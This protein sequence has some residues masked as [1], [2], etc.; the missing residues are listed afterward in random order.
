MRTT[1]TAEMVA[2]PCRKSYTKTNSGIE[3]KQ[4]KQTPGATEYT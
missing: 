1:E 2:A 4:T 3:N